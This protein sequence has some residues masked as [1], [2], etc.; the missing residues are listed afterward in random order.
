MTRK[1]LYILGFCLLVFSFQCRRNRGEHLSFAPLSLDS[2]QYVLDYELRSI[3]PIKKQLGGFLELS[4]NDDST[5]FELKT[6]ARTDTFCLRYKKFIDEYSSEN[7]VQ[8]K[9]FSYFSRS[10]LAHRFNVKDSFNEIFLV[11]IIP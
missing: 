2:N 6:T 9:D 11:V 3:W 1:A 10:G 5:V 4:A 7:V 8:F